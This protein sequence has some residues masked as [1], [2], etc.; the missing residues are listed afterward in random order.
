MEKP[1]VQELVLSLI[2]PPAAMRFILADQWTFNL[3][4]P[5]GGVIQEKALF[6]GAQGQNS[7]SLKRIDFFFMVRAAEWMD[8]KPNLFMASQISLI[9]YKKIVSQ[10]M[11]R[12]LV[13]VFWQFICFHFSA[14]C[15]D[16]DWKRFEELGGCKEVHICR[17]KLQS[18]NRCK[19][20][21]LSCKIAK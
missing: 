19:W 10:G 13:L 20:E 4:H 11:L 3:C 17:E 6:L 8:L 18:L 12:R 1:E 14:N 2:N 21:G 16:F 9:A 7:A 15:Q 5:K